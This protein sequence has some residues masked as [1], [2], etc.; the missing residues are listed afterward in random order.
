MLL[1]APR[2]NTRDILLGF[3]TESR[4]KFVI[5]FLQA[6]YRELMPGKISIS[7]EI[8]LDT[9]S[10]AEVRLCIAISAMQLGKSCSDRPLKSISFG[11]ARL[12]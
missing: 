11:A 2:P 6:V 4:W 3:L 1:H 8:G 12:G 5:Q 9:V 10:Q 7:K